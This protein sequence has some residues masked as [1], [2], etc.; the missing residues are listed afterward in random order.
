MPLSKGKGW[1]Q[2]KPDTACQALGTRQRAGERS[3]QH[4][5][6]V[7]VF[8]GRIK[9]KVEHS[10]LLRYFFYLQPLKKAII[11]KHPKGAVDTAEW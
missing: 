6:V 11:R 1:L 2:L 10:G 9:M 7:C 8:T 3:G 5:C 4:T